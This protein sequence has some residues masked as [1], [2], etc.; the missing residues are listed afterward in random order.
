M[1]CLYWLGISLNAIIGNDGII[2]NGQIA[3]I[4]SKFAGYKEELETNIVSKV[5]GDRERVNLLNENVKSY[6]PSFDENDIGNFAIIGGKLYYLGDDELSK[7]VAK[8]QKI[9]VVSEDMSIKEFEKEVENKAVYNIVKENGLEAFKYND[10]NGENKGGI[11]LFEKNFN[12]S[13]K[14]KIVTESESNKIVQKYETGW[15]F[16]P[17]GTMVDGIGEISNQY[18]IN[19]ETRK[20]SYV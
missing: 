5:E 12:N 10:G 3:S 2:T 20:N 6:I 14:W 13:T 11:E 15:Y 16:V 1:F 19:Y 9:E 7:K 4:E 8:N 17:K 18:I